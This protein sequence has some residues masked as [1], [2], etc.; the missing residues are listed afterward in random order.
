MTR[1]ETIENEINNFL[2]RDIVFFIE[3]G[4]TVKRGKLILFRF[5][6]FHFNF[7]LKTEKGDHKIYEIPYPYRCEPGINS[8]KFSYDLDDFTLKNSTLYYTAKTMN[9]DTASKLHGSKLV[10]SAV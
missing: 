4:K 6:E 2:L 3:N 5:K 1:I 7:T 10:L 9:N 8:L